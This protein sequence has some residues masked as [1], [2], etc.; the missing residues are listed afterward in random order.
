M[1]YQFHF[2]PIGFS[3]KGFDELEAQ[4]DSFE[5]GVKLVEHF[6]PEII[7]HINAVI[8]DFDKEDLEIEENLSVCRELLPNRPVIGLFNAP[9]KLDR[10]LS[11]KKPLNCSEFEIIL[12]RISGEKILQEHPRREIRAIYS[13]PDSPS[14]Y[15]IKNCFQGHLAKAWKVYQKV[16]QPIE[17]VFLNKPVLV[18]YDNK[19]SVYLSN[20]RLNQL[21]TLTI[22][23]HSMSTTL[24][25]T[26]PK[27]LQSEDAIYFIAKIA[28]WSSRG[29]LPEG[30]NSTD[31]VRLVNPERQ[32]SLP[33]IE[34]S[35][36][37]REFWLKKS[38]SLQE[39]EHVLQVQQ[40]HLFS[41][42]SALYALELIEVFP[43]NPSG[44]IKSKSKKNFSKRGW[45]EKKFY[46][47]DPVPNLL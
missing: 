5:M 21:C 11:L 6:T 7:Q 17:L 27:G 43:S 2:L 42:F 31:I 8:I 41:Y 38:C 44:K 10:V 46:K 32:Y 26:A 37:I 3:K 25:S 47:K 22:Q 39:A 28:L 30:V 20:E 29:R 4:I 36:L 18:I 34:G 1:Q 12:D 16:N 40:T 14:H 15:P 23:D 33:K 24:L 35:S 45:L 9:I 13:N 19:V